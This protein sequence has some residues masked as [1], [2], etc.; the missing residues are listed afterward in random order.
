LARL[1][2]LDAWILLLGVMHD[3]NT[4][5]HLAEYR[6]RYP[7]KKTASFG[8]PVTIDGAWRWHV[9]DDPDFDDSD[10]ARLGA[11]YE[12]NIGQAFVGRVGRAD[13]RLMRLRPMVD[14]AVRW[15]ERN[16]HGA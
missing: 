6:A 3:R 1:Y 15:M 16:R 11:D 5:L 9:V 2:D 4:S 12:Q 8:S 10:F 13:A 14:Y 7:S